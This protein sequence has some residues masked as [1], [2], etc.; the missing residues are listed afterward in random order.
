[1]VLKT[2]EIV[3]ILR[4]SEQTA[5]FSKNIQCFRR[6]FIFTFG[7]LFLIITLFIFLLLRQKNQ[8]LETVLPILK[9]MLK[10]PDENRYFI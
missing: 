4:I 8:P 10:H 2:G 7:I 6:Y 5:L 1:P 9:P 3:G